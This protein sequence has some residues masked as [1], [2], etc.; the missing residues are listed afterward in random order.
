MYW[1]ANINVT[2]KIL[3]PKKYKP[4]VPIIAR[5]NSTIKFLNFNRY[6]LLLL[7]KEI[8]LLL[9]ETRPEINSDNEHVV[10]SEDVI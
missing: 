8:D 10:I 4:S 9:Q 7:K 5:N 3:Y 6:I 1:I 2:P